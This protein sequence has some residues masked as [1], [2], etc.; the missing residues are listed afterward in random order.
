MAPPGAPASDAAAAEM[1]TC[2]G[3]GIGVWVGARFCRRCGQ[4]VEEPALSQASGN[5]AASESPTPLRGSGG[6]RKRRND[7]GAPARRPAKVSPRSGSARGTS[8]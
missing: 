8:R 1:V 5:A 2:R 7:D 4:P 3:C 6:S